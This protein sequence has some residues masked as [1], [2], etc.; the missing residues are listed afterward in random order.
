MSRDFVAKAL[1]ELKQFE[2]KEGIIEIVTRRKDG[3]QREYIH[4]AISKVKS[5][6]AKEALKEVA[7]QNNL[8]SPNINKLEDLSKLSNAI[9]IA[10]LVLEVVNLCATVAGFVIINKKMNDVMSQ[11]EQLGHTL[12]DIHD[13]DV[14]SLYDEVLLKHNDMLD[15]IKNGKEFTTDQYMNL[16]DKEYTLLKVLYKCFMKG[17]TT[18]ATNVLYLINCLSSMLASTIMYFDESYFFE[19]VRVASD[20]K[21]WHANHDIWTS[22]FDDLKSKEYQ[23]RLQD[24]MFIERQFNQYETDLF[25]AVNMDS[26]SRIKKYISDKQELLMKIG[27]RGV[28]DKIQQLIT[29]EA[30]SELK[31]KI[32]NDSMLSEPVKEECLL[33]L[34]A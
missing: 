34:S 7:Q 27:D 1:E 11:L 8:A 13:V 6:E 14:E 17:L 20:G 15:R 29:E 32:E 26:Y 12:K 16:V 5:E 10:T 25:I 21:P 23:G 24:Y 4:L 19:N 30:R 33:A 2:N 31:E 3:T 9:G 18:D 22:I 28:Y